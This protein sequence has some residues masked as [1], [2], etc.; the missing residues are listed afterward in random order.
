MMVVWMDVTTDERKV[1][2]MVDPRVVPS[3]DD[4]AVRLV[5]A[6]VVCLVVN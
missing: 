2:W 4:L 6:W 1:V 3:V 5:V